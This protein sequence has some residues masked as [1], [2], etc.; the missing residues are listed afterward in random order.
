MSPFARYNCCRRRALNSSASRGARQAL[1]ASTSRTAHIDGSPT[2]PPDVTPEKSTGVAALLE[3]QRAQLTMVG[4]AIA[5][6]RSRVK[7]S[8]HSGASSSVREDDS[9][10]GSKANSRRAA[11]P[12]HD[13]A[14][15]PLR[16][17]CMP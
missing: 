10:R 16:V 9:D 12:V 5:F 3:L 7:A 6:R 13:G 15:L 1:L 11:R 4:T 2:Y 8:R 17:Q 14:A